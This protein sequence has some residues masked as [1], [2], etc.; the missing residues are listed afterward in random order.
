MKK[1]IIIGAGIG[2]IA[3]SIRLSV[4]GYDCLILESSD[5][6]G[7]K[8]CEFTE[9]GYRFDFGPSLFT[10]PQQVDDLFTL[11]GKNP[12]NH[13]NYIKLDKSCNYFFEDGTQL[14]A[15]SDQEKF[16]EEVHEKLGVDPSVLK[17]YF[18]HSKLIYD[19]TK[20]V[21]LDKSL[22]KIS[23]YLNYDTIKALSKTHQFDLLDTM[24]SANKK[25]VK[26]PRLVQLFD[27]YATYNG[28]NPYKAPGILN[29]ISTLEH[30]DGTYFP[31]GGMYSITK[32]LAELALGLGVK[33]LYNTKAEK[34][35][36][37]NGNA[38]AVQAD[39]KTLEADIIVS[40]MDA[41]LTYKKLLGDIK[42]PTKVLN[43]ERSSS[44]LVFYWGIT[45]EFE[46]L[47]LHNIFFSSDY[48]NEFDHL[49]NKKSICDDPTAYVNITSKYCKTDSPQGHENWFVMINAPSMAGQDWDS[50][51]ARTRRNVIAKL[52]RMLKTDIEP[53][54]ES[55]SITD[56]R[57]VE[58][59][60][61]SY[62]GSLYGTSS[63]QR[64]A[65]FFRHPNFSRKIKNLY[66][67][68]GSV[69]P[70]GGI[71]LCLMSAKIV[72]SLVP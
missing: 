68:G 19:V 12:R 54:I 40:N 59:K 45:K 43:Q 13:F 2:G 35:L 25:R 26:D 57:L 6:P 69:H 14:N 15:Y 65:A 5:G 39:G 20:P 70:G 72:D 17:Q 7:G 60:T 52:S 32:S 55:E 58:S 34:I 61:M 50:I 23:S 9:N 51:V 64:L 11:A 47:H 37:H 66:F 16:G 4:K 21:F 27:R 48:E 3:T 63:N 30:V 56:P 33:I 42:G 44:A 22:H 8:L 67:C 31:E 46:N 41:Y 29:L 36:Y 62:Q 38:T 18:D 10:L 28:S 53:L 49:F 24:H 71:P 1:A